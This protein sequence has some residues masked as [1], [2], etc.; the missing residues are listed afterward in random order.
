[1]FEKV[2][3]LSRFDAPISLGAPS[4]S[5]SMDQ[6]KHKRKG[7]SECNTPLYLSNFGEDNSAKKNQVSRKGNEGFEKVVLLLILVLLSL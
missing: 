7:I 5:R 2:K 3:S 4:F 1:M 6:K